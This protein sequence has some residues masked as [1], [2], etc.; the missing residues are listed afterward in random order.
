MGSVTRSFKHIRNDVK[1]EQKVFLVEVDK[2]SRGDIVK[3]ID[4]TSYATFSI[5]IGMG[6][7]SWLCIVVKEVHA[8]RSSE[9]FFRKFN[10][11]MNKK[12]Y[13]ESTGGDY[14]SHESSQRANLVSEDTQKGAESNYRLG[15]L[16]EITKEEKAT[17][18]GGVID[19]CENS[20]FEA[21]QHVSLPTLLS[22]VLPSKHLYR[23][24][25]ELGA[26]IR[27]GCESFDSGFPSFARESVPS[28]RNEEGKSSSLSVGSSKG[29]GKLINS[30]LLVEQKE[31]NLLI[32]NGNKGA[33][34]S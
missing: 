22:N 26:E 7:V 3:I 20:N 19:Q 11:N 8:W 9:T 16:F 29:L 30:S 32:C 2:E 6:G 14:S 13:E 10:D 18:N 17:T 23:S 4:R 27:R 21:C 24:S 1:I 15:G 31:C 28:L 25:G 33:T 12:G 34:G 5:A